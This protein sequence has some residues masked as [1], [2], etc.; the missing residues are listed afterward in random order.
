MR[1]VNLPK[2]RVYVRKDAF[3]G[4]S[5]EFEPAWLVSVRAV[6]NR[7]FVFQVWVDA[8]AACYDKIPPHCLYWYEPDGDQVDLPLHKIQMWE[9][10]SGS[11]EL[12]QKSQLADVPVLVNL[13]K[14]MEPITGHYWFTLDFLPEGSGIGMPDVGDVELFEE[15]KEANVIKL[16]NGQLAI[17]PNNR[18]K[19]LPVSLTPNGAAARIPEWS[20]ATNEQWDDWWCD[21]T[22]ILGDAKWAY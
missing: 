16:A 12:W 1:N 20:V 10:L 13:G 8:F 5:I 6:R 14:G 19:W 3:G 21:S 17:Y 22:E 7:L 15:H 9:C 18:L 4:S 11:V 2:A